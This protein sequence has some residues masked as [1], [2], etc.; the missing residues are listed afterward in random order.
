M[1]DIAE[2]VRNH[3]TLCCLNEQQL[4]MT[5]DFRRLYKGAKE[6]FVLKVL[7]R[8]LGEKATNVIRTL[9][10]KYFWLIWLCIFLFSQFGRA[11]MKVLLSCKTFDW[12]I[13]VK[14]YSTN[15]CLY[16]IILVFVVQTLG[17]GFCFR[18]ELSTMLVVLYLTMLC[19]LWIVLTIIF[20]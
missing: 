9:Y 14:I 2:V 20:F 3:K 11:S 19:W 17:Y 12:T 5:W 15:V 18:S 13:F 6:G 8:F 10:C 16:V 7:K 1:A 4:I